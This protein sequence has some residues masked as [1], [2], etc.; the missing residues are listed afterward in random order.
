ME[1][2]TVQ[3]SGVL[4]RRQSKHHTKA[5]WLPQSHLN[6]DLE[7]DWQSGTFPCSAALSEFASLE[8]NLSRGFSLKLGKR[9]ALI[10]SSGASEKIADG[11]SRLWC[12]AS[13]EVIRSGFGTTGL[14]QPPVKM[15]QKR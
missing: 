12:G 6:L 13:I 2:R 9:A 14:D 3:K 8:L 11:S 4:Q 5:L 1:R 15:Q 10:E 7:I